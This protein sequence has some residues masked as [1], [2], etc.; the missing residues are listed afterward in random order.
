MGGGCGPRSCVGACGDRPDRQS[1]VSVEEGSHA[2]HLL[3]EVAALFD[4]EWIKRLHR[5]IKPAARA[6]LMPNSSNGSIDEEHRIVSCLPTWG[7]RPLCGPP[8]KEP[9]ARLAADD[10]GVEVGKQPHAVEH[11]GREGCISSYRPCQAAVDLH[12]LK[13]TRQSV[14]QFRRPPPW[15]A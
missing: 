5:D 10:V 14:K 12:R 2:L 1:G 3:I 6:P 13:F 11:I 15:G 4:S 7:Q 8:G 9:F